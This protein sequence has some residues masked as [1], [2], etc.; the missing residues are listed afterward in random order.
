M[1]QFMAHRREEWEAE[2][3]VAYDDGDTLAVLSGRYGTSNATVMRALAVTGPIRTRSEAHLR[4]SKRRLG[5]DFFDVI[6]TEP[7]AYWFGFLVAD[8]CIITGRRPPEVAVSV[9][10]MGSDIEHLRKLAAIVGANVWK[11]DR[12]PSKDG[13]RMLQSADMKMGTLIARALLAKGVCQRKSYADDLT[14]VLE[15]VPPALWRHFL[16]GMID[17][18]GWAFAS[19]RDA[20]TIGVCGNARLMQLL[21]D[22]AHA[23]LGV[24]RPLVQGDPNSIPVFGKVKWSHKLDSRKLRDW[25]YA[26]ATVWLPRKRDAC[27]ALGEPAGS[28]YRG[29][30]AYQGK[31]RV[32]LY[33]GGRKGPTVSGGVHRTE[34]EAALAYDRKARE[35]YGNGT[36][37]NIAPEGGRFDL[38][39][40]VQETTP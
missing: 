31:W 19:G 4:N 29:V 1:T 18:N 17:A 25:I 6:D 38:W 12:C 14:G 35:L 3:R 5:A 10:V 9:S 23:R 33:P 11:R 24:A 16:R 39:P 7:K 40:H 2:L 26:D 21:V 22:F 32:A 13:Q 30:L 28:W 34:L 36:A 27:A 20:V 37:Q 8:G 15:H